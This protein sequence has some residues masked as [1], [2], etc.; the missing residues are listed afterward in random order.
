ME[1][2]RVLIPEMEEEDFMSATTP[3]E[4]DARIIAAINRFDV[5]AALAEYDPEAAFVVAGE[6][7]AGPEAVRTV[8]EGFIATKPDLT[9]EVKSCTIAGDIAQL[10]AAWKLTGQDPEGKAIEM[11]GRS[12]EVMRRQADGGWKMLIDNPNGAD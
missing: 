8:L 2:A 4:C 3:E 10:S 9:L 7:H 12:M 1:A 6:T 11:A 5:E